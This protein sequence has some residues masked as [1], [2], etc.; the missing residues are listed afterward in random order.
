MG[1]LDNI[2]GSAVPGGNMSKP[3][4]IALLALLAYKATHGNAGG[5]GGGLLDSILGGGGNQP[6][7][8][9]LQPEQREQM[10]NAIPDGLNGLI[11]RFRQSGLGGLVSSWIGTGNNQ[12]ISPNQLNQA[13]E[14]HEIDEL[15]RQTGMNRQDVLS[16]LS[17]ALPSLVDRLT[18]AG[19]VPQAAEMSRW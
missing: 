4:G 1:L 16:Q 9:P 12:Q 11:D 14:P 17:Q 7:S 6:G 15:S 8:M 19:R 2:L 10:Q 13:L 18:P 3:L 5:G